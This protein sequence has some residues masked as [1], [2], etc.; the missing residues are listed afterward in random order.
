MVNL[1]LIEEYRDLSTVIVSDALDMMTRRNH[2][3]D[4]AIQKRAGGKLVGP[5]VT[6]L[7]G[8]T[9][10]RVVHTAS[11]QVIDEAEAGS[12]VIVGV[13]SELNAAMWGDLE[14]AT[15]RA[16]GL[17][18]VVTDGAVRQ[19]NPD[20]A[21]GFSIFSAAKSPAGGYGRLKALVPN[22]KIRCG[23]VEISPGDLIVADD[24]GVV[25]VPQTLVRNV[26]ANAKDAM[27]RQQKLLD[28]ALATRSIR[29]AVRLHWDW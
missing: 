21:T 13:E 17:A 25:A 18:G 16:R 22:A 2:V 1:R 9:S 29:E 12:V 26:L 10:E 27:R 20:L 8:L 14:T 6:V 15:A 24:N 11:M 3:L 5:A 28:V 4:A 7:T 19:N 23:G